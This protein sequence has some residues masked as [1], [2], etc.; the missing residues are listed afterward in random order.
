MRIPISF[1]MAYPGRLKSREAG[2]DFFTAAS[3]M[4]FEKPDTEVFR[5]IKIAYEASEAGGTYPAAMNGANE[6][7]VD[8]FLKGKI[9]FIDI[10]NILEKIIEK[11]NPAYNL[12]LEGIMEA[13]L[14]ARAE[15]YEQ[16]RQVSL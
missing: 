14:K 5:C 12:D 8:L 15:A 4:T 11:H 10:Q 2:L 16:A 3:T 13:D 1:A 7:L 9:R 6:A